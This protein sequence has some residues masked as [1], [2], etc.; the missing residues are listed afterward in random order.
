MLSAF[1]QY[2]QLLVRFLNRTG[3]WSAKDIRPKDITH[4]SQERFSNETCSGVQE[5]L[6]LR[7][8]L[9]HLFH[10]LYYEINEL[11]L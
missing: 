7:D 9:V 5:Q 1:D 10:E 6:H 8:L 2:Q 3:S 4:R 11:V